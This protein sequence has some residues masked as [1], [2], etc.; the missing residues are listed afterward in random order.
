MRSV[1]ELTDP[2]LM[3]YTLYIYITIIIII[4]P[5]DDASKDEDF[6]KRDNKGQNDISKGGVNI[7]C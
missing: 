2:I 5:T 4:I 7:E 6:Q 1:C 3:M